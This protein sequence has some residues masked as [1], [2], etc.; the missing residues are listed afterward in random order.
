M[1]DR[2]VVLD[3]G[4][5]NNQL[6]VRRIRQIG[7]YAALYD[8]Q[9]PLSQWMD[10]DVKGIVLTGGPHRYTKGQAV[11]L[12]PQVL[13][14]GLPVLGICYGLQWMA[15]Q[16]GGQVEKLARGDYG[17]VPLKVNTQVRFFKGV[18]QQSPIWMDREDAVTVLP[19][20]FKRIA[21]AD[22]YPI[23]AI[24]DEAA[25]LYGVQFHP[26][27]AQS[28]YGIKMLE[29]FV[30][31]ICGCQKSWIMSKIADR[32]IQEVADQ[33]GDQ[34]V[35]C[36]LSG[37]INSSVAGLVAARTSSASLTCLFVDNGLLRQN[38]AETVMEVY[39]D[40]GLDVVYLDAKDRFLEALEGVDNAGEK[41]RIIFDL[42]HKVFQ[43]EADRLGGFDLLIDPTTYSDFIRRRL[44]KEDPLYGSTKTKLSAYF[45]GVVQ[46]LKDLFKDEVRLLG[47][48]L[49][50]DEDIVDRQPFPSSGLALRIWG[51]VTQDRLDILRQAD[52]IFEEE[53]AFSGY[54]EDLWDYFANLVPSPDGSQVIILEAQTSQDG[55]YFETADLPFDLLKR[56]SDRILT[57]VDQVSR[58]VYDFSPKT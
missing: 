11:S 7:V 17:Q 2:I 6:I 54:D 34:K 21:W 48:A 15:R 9:T 23:A 42:F 43:E 55:L 52:K 53:I 37:G 27:V 5:K 41:R 1:K 39:Q 20:G 47:R 51:Q 13:N 38:E 24:A 8:A 45:Q 30:F 50:L 10:S 29:N 28:K 44:G 49:G 40:L 46:P 32:L 19:K 57:E 22:N 14:L 56:V 35:F 36:A 26:E 12:D 58:V 16:K 4:G 31:D 33:I 3:F 18:P 25:G